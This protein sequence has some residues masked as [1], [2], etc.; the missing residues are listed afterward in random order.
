MADP[1]ALESGHGLELAILTEFDRICTEED[2]RYYL[3]YGTLLGAVRHQG[4]I[5]WD[6]DVDVIVTVEEY[7]R[8]M[9]ALRRRLDPDKWTLHWHEYNPDY[10]QLLARI[11]AA[12]VSLLKARF[13]IFP[14][15]GAPANPLLARLV[16]VIAHVNYRAF[17]FK[18]VDIA[19]NYAD[20]PKLARLA[21][22]IKWA[23]TPFP[24]SLFVRVQR[25]LTTLVPL[26]RAAWVQNICGSYGARERIPAAWLSEVERL[27]FEGLQLPVPHEWDAYLRQMYGDYTV[28]RVRD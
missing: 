21:R 14:V 3:A 9:D 25:W 18:K 24:A 1:Q 28:P 16:Q 12:G 15:A 26:D 17:F 19:V 2:I 23:L 7:P 20:R 4:F 13:D 8:L 22:P 10:D 27:P 5:P 11:G 6:L